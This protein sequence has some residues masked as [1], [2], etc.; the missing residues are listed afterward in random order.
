MEANGL[1]S[2][3]FAPEGCDVARVQS[4]ISELD[5]ILSE[6]DP[7]IDD[8]RI[9]NMEMEARNATGLRMLGLC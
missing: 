5:R 7:K 1:I 4:S 2:R 3:V 6:Y 8:Q 9:E